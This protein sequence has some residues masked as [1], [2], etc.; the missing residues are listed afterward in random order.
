M[1]FLDIWGAFHTLLV[2]P[3]F[4]GFPSPTRTINSALPGCR[5]MALVV[6]LMPCWLV[7]SNPD[8]FTVILF[9]ALILVA[10]CCRY[11]CYLTVCAVGS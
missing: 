5:V 6:E 3:E 8:L 10:A 7:E 2:W 1:S 11:M 9:A 4:S